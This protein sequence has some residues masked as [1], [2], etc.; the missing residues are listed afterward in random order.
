[1]LKL[2]QREFLVLL[3]LPYKGFST[4]VFEECAVDEPIHLRPVAA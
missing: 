1:M 2:G 4:E 3:E